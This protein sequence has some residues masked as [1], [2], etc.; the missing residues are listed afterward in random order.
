MLE[1]FGI[2]KNIDLEPETLGRTLHSGPRTYVRDR[3]QDPRF[4]NLKVGAKAL[5]PDLKDWTRDPGSK[6][7]EKGFLS[8]IGPKP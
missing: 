1:D 6:F 7:Q 3:T 5:D 4:R 8:Q 2:S